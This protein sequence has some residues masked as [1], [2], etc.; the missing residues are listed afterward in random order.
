MQN[1]IQKSKEWAFEESK[2]YGTPYPGHLDLAYEV[3]QSIATKLGGVDKDIVAIG[4]YLMDIKL[5]QARA[6]GKIELHTKISADAVVEFLKQFNLPEK[7]SEIIINCVEAHHATIPYKSIE[8]EIC[9]NADCYRFL[10]P[11]GLFGYFILHG[12]RSLDLDSGTEKAAEKIEEK[13]NILS[14][15]I[16]KQ[17]LEPYYKMFKTLI[18]EARKIEI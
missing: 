14:L 11:R 5:G 13:W 17:E 4:T 9:A 12:S 1:I 18:T 2:K 16:C 10:H 8:A 3:G 6:E 15:D 7:I